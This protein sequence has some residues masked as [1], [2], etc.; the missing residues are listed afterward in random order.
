MTQ[1]AGIGVLMQVFFLVF[2]LFRLGMI[3]GRGK[4]WLFPTP[5]AEAFKRRR[6]KM[7]GH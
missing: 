6:K 3:T 4:S 1:I 7:R 2:F 5:E